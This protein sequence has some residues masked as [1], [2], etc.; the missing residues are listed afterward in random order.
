MV[1]KDTRTQYWTRK[2]ERNDKGANN[3]IGVYIYFSIIYCSGLPI[4]VML[5]L[6]QGNFLMIDALESCSLSM[7]LTVR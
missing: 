5:L 4:G 6:M 2:Q 3:G 7:G 1:E